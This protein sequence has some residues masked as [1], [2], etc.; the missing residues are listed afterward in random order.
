VSDLLEEVNIWMTRWPDAMAAF[1]ITAEGAHL[2]PDTM[3]FSYSR[4]LP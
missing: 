3:E 2:H 4:E 1:A